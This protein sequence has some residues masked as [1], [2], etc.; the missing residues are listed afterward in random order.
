MG[1]FTPAGP[2]LFLS[3]VMLRELD[4]SIS[5]NRTVSTKCCKV[6]GPAIFPCLLACATIRIVSSWFLVRS[7]WNALRV[8][9]M[10]EGEPGAEVVVLDLTALM[11]SRTTN[12]GWGESGSGGL[13]EVEI[14]GRNDGTVESWNDGSAECWIKE[15]LD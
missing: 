13:G 6:R 10:F 15:F 12:V 2:N 4:L 1:V 7:A 3:V 5:S 9:V 8:L 14:K 11:E